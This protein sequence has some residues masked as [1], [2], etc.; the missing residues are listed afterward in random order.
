MISLINHKNNTGVEKNVYSC[1]QAEYSFL[2][3]YFKIYLYL[4]YCCQ[5][6]PRLQSIPLQLKKTDMPRNWTIK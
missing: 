1:V 6:I 2:T 4:K 5:Y 3:A